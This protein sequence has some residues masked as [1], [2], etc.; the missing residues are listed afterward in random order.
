MSHRCFIHSSI[1]G[2]LDCLYLL[3]IVNNAA[4]NI[5]VLMFFSISVLGSFGYIPRSGMLGQKA[6]SFLIV[7]RHL[8]TAFHSGCT[9]PYSHQQCKSVALFPH[10]HQHLFVDLLMIAIFTG[11]RCCLIVVSMCI[12]I[13]ISDP[14]H[15]FIC[16]LVTFWM[17]RGHREQ[18]LQVSSSKGNNPIMGAPPSSTHLTLITYQRLNL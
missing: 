12:S 1:G 13:M 17:L 11:V 6:D 2:H 4:M 8:H 15:L 5:G 16:M 9:S 7:L 3:V 14:E 18:A 10:P